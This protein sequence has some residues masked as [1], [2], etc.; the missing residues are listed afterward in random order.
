MTEELT[1]ELT[2]IVVST[3]P[4]C[5][6]CDNLARYDGETDMGLWGYMCEEHYKQHGQG[7]GL[8]VG[9]KLLLLSEFLQQKPVEPPPLPYELQPGYYIRF[10]RDIGYVTGG[11]IYLI[12]DIRGCLSLQKLG[13]LSWSTW[14]A[15]NDHLDIK[16][17]EA[18]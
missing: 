2:E 10:D 17:G 14:Q 15:S 16:G 11:T 1:E 3:L 6:F 12:E 4:Q 7:L 5:D 13:K 9:Q 8:G 18:I